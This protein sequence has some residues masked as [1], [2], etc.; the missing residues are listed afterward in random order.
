M[1]NTTKLRHWLLSVALLVPM[2]TGMAVSQLAFADT[3]PTPT[4]E[5]LTLSSDFPSIKDAEGG[6]Y[7]FTVNIAYVGTDPRLFDLSAQNPAGSSV[8]IM[9]SSSVEVTA[10]RIDPTVFSS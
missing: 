1:F 5:S 2:A 7:S 4:P 10:I 8:Q 6:Q 9:N 3:T